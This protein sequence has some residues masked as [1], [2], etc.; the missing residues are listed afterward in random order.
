MIWEVIYP[1]PYSWQTTQLRLEPTRDPYTGACV[2]YKCCLRVSAVVAAMP[3]WLTQPALGSPSYSPLPHWA[4]GTGRWLSPSGQFR[5]VWLGYLVINDD[6]QENIRVS[7]C[8]SF[9]RRKI[10]RKCPQSASV[11]LHK[12]THLSRCRSLWTWH[13]LKS[14][15][16]E[17]EENSLIKVLSPPL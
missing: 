8:S 5:R 11:S 7:F 2:R 12:H 6:Q 9:W 4:S 17:C 1:R 10:P 15:I 14:R 13:Y 3:R 16:S